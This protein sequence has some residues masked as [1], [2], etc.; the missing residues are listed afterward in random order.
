MISH[1][2][3]SN[4][5]PSEMDFSNNSKPVTQEYQ[6]TDQQWQVEQPS[7]ESYQQ[8]E[9][10]NSSYGQPA[11]NYQNFELVPKQE[12]SQDKT[13]WYQQQES[14]QSWEESQNVHSTA[15]DKEQTHNWQNEQNMVSTISH[16]YKYVT[17]F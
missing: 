17:V 1:Q 13:Y 9:E 10:Q 2:S 3:L 15:E 14:H 8:N 4:L 12:M 16:N 6:T 11:L 5:S 7:A